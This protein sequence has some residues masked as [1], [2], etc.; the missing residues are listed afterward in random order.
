MKSFIFCCFVCV[1]CC[2]FG[3]ECDKII[4]KDGKEV[5]SLIEEIGISEIT[6]RKCDNTATSPK[7]VVSKKDISK[8]QLRDGTIQIVDLK[9]KEEKE[10]HS[11]LKKDSRIIYGFDFYTGMGKQLF[12]RE[13]ITFTD[14][15][16]NVSRV[17]WKNKPYYGGSAYLD[18]SIG[19]K[20]YL[21]INAGLEHYPK[22]LG[23]LEYSKFYFPLEAEYK[24]FNSNAKNSIGFSLGVGYSF[25]TLNQK[26][27][28][29]QD[30][31]NNN[32]S[33]EYLVSVKNFGLGSG[34]II[35]PTLFY[36]KQIGNFGLSFK[37]GYRVQGYSLNIQ[38]KNNTNNFVEFY[39]VGALQSARLSVG[40]S[41]IHYRQ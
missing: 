11:K 31:A 17:D 37:L 23:F 30:P 21:G 22:S 16:G 41:R 10:R 15:V 28:S 14:V 7:I 38:N 1:S 12:K 32:T 33:T 9:S 26:S 25:S 18:I 24:L 6:Y 3:Q 34:L 13:E 8:I 35:S 20:S 27:V 5:L 29:Y 39:P 4:F 19:S 2:V 36:T 40:I